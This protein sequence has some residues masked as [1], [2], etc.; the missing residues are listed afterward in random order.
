MKKARSKHV[1]MDLSIKH[2]NMVSHKRKC[3]KTLNM[4]KKEIKTLDPN[5]L[6]NAGVRM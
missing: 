4:H 6:L 2:P 5:F 1:S 3:I